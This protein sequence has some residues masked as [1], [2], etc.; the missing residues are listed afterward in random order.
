MSDTTTFD[1]HCHTHCSD[2]ALAPGDLID[3]AV[4][5]NLQ[6]LAITDHDTVA[7]YSREL[8]EYADRAGITLIVGCEISC[9]WERR[10]VHVVGLNMDLEHP[11]FTKAMT[12]QMKARERRAE[13]ITQVLQ[14]L[15]FSIELSQIEKIAKTGTIGRPHFAQYLVATH[16]VASFAA[17]FKQ[18]LG[19][20]KAGDIKA[21]WPSLATAV[22][23]I[24]DAGGVA[25]VAHP[26]KYKMT[27][28]KLR[29]LLEDFKAAGGC[30]IEVVTGHQPPSQTRTLMDLANRFELTASAGSDFHSPGQPWAELGR[31]SALPESSTPIWQLWS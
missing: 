22:S 3:L 24:T 4:A 1:F 5:R 27:L 2:G 19:S 12:N 8:I 13:Q 16:Q 28:T 9:V 21:E 25:V 18:V 15:G 7:A 10:S 23:W 20:G 11:T 26:L 30:G 31:A 6:Q 29:R 14:R 17:A